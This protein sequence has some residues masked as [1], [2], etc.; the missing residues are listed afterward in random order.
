MKVILREDVANLGRMGDIVN[1]KPGYARNFLI[2]GSLALE[3]DV[4]NVKAF[5]HQ[6]A[7]IEARA[8]KMKDAAKTLGEKLSSLAVTIRAKAGEE[9]KLF[10][11]VT[12]MDIAEALKAQGVD[13]DKKKLLLDEPIK[14][15]GSFEVGI[16]L[17]SDVT[18]KLKVEVV[19]ESEA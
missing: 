2:P 6:K 10:G 5:E 16:K 14:R 13:I 11:S 3:A 8:K 12:A 18:A 9:E 7:A 15:L 1:V 4:K 19:A 17:S